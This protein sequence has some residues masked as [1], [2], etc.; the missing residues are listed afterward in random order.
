MLFFR[1]RQVYDMLSAKPNHP[2]IATGPGDKPIGLYPACGVI[3][4]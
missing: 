2:L 4:V 1:D 3:P